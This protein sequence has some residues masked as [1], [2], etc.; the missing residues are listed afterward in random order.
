[1]PP[2]P[3]PVHAYDSARVH[4]AALCSRPARDAA[5]R[6][7]IRADLEHLTGT[8]SAEDVAGI[9]ESKAEVLEV[10]PPAPR[11]VPRSPAAVRRADAPSPRARA[12]WLR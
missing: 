6:I 3:R 12:R 10:P 7:G 8:V 2:H 11:G 1:M 4:R 5:Q 9:D